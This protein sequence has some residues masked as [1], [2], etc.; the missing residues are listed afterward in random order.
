MTSHQKLTSVVHGKAFYNIFR[1]NLDVCFFYCFTVV[2]TSKTTLPLLNFTLSCWNG[3]LMLQR[4]S[5]QREFNETCNVWNNKEIRINNIIA[6]FYIKKFWVWC[7][8]S[9]WPFCVSWIMWIPLRL[10]PRK[11]IEQTPTFRSSQFWN[12][13][14]SSNLSITF[15]LLMIYSKDYIAY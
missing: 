4:N 2:T 10:F 1:I 6:C 5:S 12:K 3:G 14:N 11:S 8:L 15:F 7:Y 13:I 9:Y